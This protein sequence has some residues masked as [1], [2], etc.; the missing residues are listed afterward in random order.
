MQTRK[1]KKK[2]KKLVSSRKGE[3][4]ITR[5]CAVLW[6]V[7]N[8]SLGSIVEFLQ[9]FFFFLVGG[10]TELSSWS[11][12]LET[13]VDLSSS[14]SSSHHTIIFISVILTDTLSSHPPSRHLPRHLLIRPSL[15]SARKGSVKPLSP[16]LRPTVEPPR[17][18]HST[19]IFDLLDQLSFS[20]LLGIG[21]VLLP[22]LITQK[23]TAISA[24]STNP[25]L[26]SFQ[27][28]RRFRCWYVFFLPFLLPRL[29]SVAVWAWY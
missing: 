12:H 8:S 7:E 14:S 3:Q 28:V 9:L 16:P 17:H 29:C 19:F 15:L 20:F 11:V 24:P 23:N 13:F 1:K 26:T 18:P 22:P 2:K 5:L 27:N 6:C 21:S 4:A 25:P 10:G